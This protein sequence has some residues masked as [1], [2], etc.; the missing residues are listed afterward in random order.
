MIIVTNSKTT[1]PASQVIIAQAAVQRCNATVTIDS[2]NK[3]IYPPTINNKEMYKLFQRVTGDMIGA[4]GVKDVQPMMGA[5]DFS[6]YQELI[7]GYYFLLGMKDEA[8]EQPAP[9]HSPYF[10]INEDALHVGAALHTS[11]AMI[12]LLENQKET[13][14]HNGYHHDGL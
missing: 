12:Y 14:A 13:H 2:K 1:S 6:F 10:R 4:S 8:L 9:V 11:L 5:E 3:P 7:S